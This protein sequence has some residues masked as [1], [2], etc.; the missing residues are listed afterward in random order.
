MQLQSSNASRKKNEAQSKN[1]SKKN[2]A[3]PCVCPGTEKIESCNVYS[4]ESVKAATV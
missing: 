2:E 1:M 3:Y 4:R